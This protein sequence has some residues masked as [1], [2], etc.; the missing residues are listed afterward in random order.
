MRTKQHLLMLLALFLAATSTAFA[1]KT[2]TTANYTVDFNTPISVAAHDF[3]VAAGWSHAVES[4]NSYYGDSYYVSYVYTAHD[5]VDSTGALLV[6]N[7]S[8]G[9]YYSPTAVKD[10]LVTPKLS[11]TATI[12]VK[13]QTA[14]SSA[15]AFYNVTFDSNGKPVRSKVIDADI[16]AL[17]KDSFITVTLPQTENGYVGIY[18]QYVY[19]DDFHA[20]YASTVLHNRMSIEDVVSLT[21]EENY[22]NENNK[23]QVSAK[24]VVKNSGDLTLA[25][26]TANYA[27]GIYN[28]TADTLL[29][30]LPLTQ[31]LAPGAVSDTILVSALVDGTAFPDRNRYDVIELLNLNHTQIGWVNPHAY[32]PVLVVKDFRGA[33]LTSGIAQHFGTRQHDYTLTYTIANTG[34]APLEISAISVGSD[35]QT[36]LTAPATVDAFSSTALSITMPA[37]TQGK[38]A[39]TLR[40]ATNAGDFLMPID[41]TVIDSTLWYADFEEG[42]L[43]FNMI[44]GE[45]WSVEAYSEYLNLDGNYYNLRSKYAT[46]L[47]KV[48][49]PLLNVA[50]G[51]SITF[52]AGRIGYESVL[53][54][55]YS[56]DRKNWTL[57]RTLSV[58]PENEADKFSTDYEQAG[59]YSYVYYPKTFSIKNIP[60]GRWYMAFESGNAYVDNICGYHLATV[61]HDVILNSSSIPAKGMVNSELTATA[62]LTNLTAKAEQSGNYT[63][64]LVFDNDVVVTTE[65]PTLEPGKATDVTFT[66]TPHAAGTHKAFARF[67]FGDLV[68]TTDT[69]D[70]VIAEESGEKDVV[71]GNPTKFSR[72]ASPLSMYNN[73][74]NSETIYTE[75][76]L[77]AKGIKAGQKISG[78]T[79]Y[80]YFTSGTETTVHVRAYI[81]NTAD[82]TIAEAE[83]DTTTMTKAFEGACAYTHQGSKTAPVPMLSL[84][85]NEPFVYTGGNLRVS[86]AHGK[87]AG[88]NN[89][90][91]SVYFEQ[92]ADDTEHS[93]ARGYDWS[94]SNSTWTA[95]GL[96]VTH[97]TVIAEP[98]VVLGT[99]TDGEEAVEGAVVRLIKGNV[100]Y[101]D[102]T[103]ADGTFKVNVVQAGEKYELNVQAEGYQTYSD[104]LL[105][106][107]DTVSNVAVVLSKPAPAM[108]P[109]IYA[110]IYQ[111]DSWATPQRGIYQFKPESTISFTKLSPQEDEPTLAPLGGAAVYDG[112]LHGVYYTYNE[113]Y[114]FEYVEYDTRSW[115]RT[116]TEFVQ[117]NNLAAT[118]NVSLDPTTGKVWGQF[119]NFNLD[120]QV[121]D[122]KWASVDYDNLKKTII[123]QLNLK[124]VSTAINSK[125]RCYV[126]DDQGKLYTM[127]QNTATTEEV[128]AT[129]LT[130]NTAKPMSAAFDLSGDVLYWAAQTS[131]GHSGLYTVDTLTAQATLVALFPA[132]EVVVNMWIP[133][134]EAN[135]QAPDSVRSLSAQFEGSSLSGTVAFTMPT[136]TYGGDELHEPVAYRI[137]DADGILVDSTAAAVGAQI[138][139]PVTF[140]TEGEKTLSVVA[141]NEFGASPVNTISLFVGNDTPLA[142]QNVKATVDE[143]TGEV[144]ISWQAPTEGVHGKDLSNAALLYRVVQ[145]P[146]STE[147]TATLAETAYTYEL[148][149]SGPAHG[150]TYLVSA[151]N[152]GNEGEAALSNRIVAGDAYDVPYLE[153]FN[154]EAAMD[155]YTVIDGNNDGMS[156]VFNKSTYSGEGRAAIE[157]PKDQMENDWLITPPINLEAEKVYTVSFEAKKNFAP[158]T[159]NQLLDVFIG[160]GYDTT[161][162]VQVNPEQ[163][164]VY[165]VND[166]TFSYNV[167][168][169]ATGRYHVALRAQSWP[170][171]DKLFVRNIKVVFNAEATGITTIEE[172]SA[173]TASVY[174]LSGQLIGRDVQ[175]KSLPK[176][177]YIINGKK[178]VVK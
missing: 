50:E 4:V 42:E 154:S 27:L 133:L 141:L 46:P 54:I 65:G 127:N 33:T 135:A 98:T 114:V 57:V 143:T 161:A 111:S 166:E 163:I 30:T 112:K 175:V 99:V 56:A 62:S 115:Q 151:I 24:V 95:V 145:V 152:A 172:T 126:I 125:G 96:P 44:A 8:I 48:I 26:D 136:T 146:D 130:L 5:G 70:L 7:Q 47:T 53:N 66:L 173:T 20:D 177:V 67:T 105:V 147:L 144:S 9:S 150:Y 86:V 170:N 49:S 76:M 148:T 156:W 40:I 138:Q 34:S 14:Y 58:N 162:Y 36:S 137:S 68:L 1:D 35:F 69:V 117:Y 140:T 82:A 41:G 174:T 63:A 29:Y 55:Y 25:A 160:Q 43:P 22:C 71:V 6:E 139:V 132:N 73:N 10:L 17:V 118:S 97:F 37:T 52:D 91:A 107:G 158:S 78:L 153:P 12:K 38:K 18:G 89:S 94:V 167:P 80:G 122:R 77:S 109:R 59:Y 120:Y 16:P 108:L 39:D 106:E 74:S 84:A 131:D 45:N 102:T 176:G 28:V 113:G 149:A 104:S 178:T 85:F 13:A 116:R 88:F 101:T 119:Y 169:K 72:E 110:G 23:F 100:E 75:E 134:P 81:E 64:E 168:I 11:G 87:E 164:I 79:Y 51:D 159:Y 171:T 3:A 129:G 124:L 128:G 93:R 92:D 165:Q 19:F 21:P 61:D 121:V 60:A 90:W 32:A 123:D 142:P 155:G 2:E 15:L 103:A 31:T 83:H 157:A